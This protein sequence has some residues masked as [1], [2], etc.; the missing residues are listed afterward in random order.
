MLYIII[1]GKLLDNLLKDLNNLI[2]SFIYP[3]LILNCQINKASKYIQSIIYCYTKKNINSQILLENQI[4]YT[5]DY[6]DKLLLLNELT[7]Y[8]NYEIIEASKAKC[9]NIN[10]N[11]SSNYSKYS[12][13][14]LFIIFIFFK[15][16]KSSKF[17]MHI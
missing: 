2:I 13:I 16:F 3:K 17:K 6:S 4:S 10:L 7:L 8:Q 12:F 15:V 14:I 5:K 1:K 9:N 11:K